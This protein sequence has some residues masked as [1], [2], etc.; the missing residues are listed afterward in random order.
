MIAAE[1][2]YMRGDYARA[3][4][5]G[6]QRAGQILLLGDMQSGTVTVGG[7][8]DDHLLVVF[9]D[10]RHADRAGH[11]DVGLSALVTDL[12]DALSRRK[13]PDLDLCREVRASPCAV[14]RVTAGTKEEVDLFLKS[15]EEV[16]AT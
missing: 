5:L 6:N 2:A 11:H 9:V 13:R 10:G 1:S 16:L 3:R 4:R 7:L 15:L 8:I 12:V 14:L